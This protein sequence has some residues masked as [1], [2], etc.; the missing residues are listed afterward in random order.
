FRLPAAQI[1]QTNVLP[2]YVTDGEDPAIS[3]DGR[4]LAFLRESGGKTE[5]LIFKDSG[6]PVPLRGAGRLNDLLLMRVTHEGNMIG[7]VGGAANPRLVL[8]RSDSGQIASFDEIKGSVRYPAMAADNN[9]LA[10]SRRESGSWHLF[11]RDLA[12]KS[13]RQLAI[14]PCNT[15]SP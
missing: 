10:F 1:G 3:S 7:A 14:G 5:I 9:R 6:P 15:T 8:L 4:W 12:A 11:I 13:E 2:E